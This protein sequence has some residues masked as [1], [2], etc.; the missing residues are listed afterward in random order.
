MVYFHSAAK[1]NC[2][3]VSIKHLPVA[4][5]PNFLPNTSVAAILSLIPA[6]LETKCRVPGAYGS[7]D[8]KI[9]GSIKILLFEDVT[10]MTAPASFLINIIF[11]FPVKVVAARILSC[12]SSILYKQ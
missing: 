11:T 3:M 8:V 4:Q 5:T 10:A 1:V 9:I 12:Y 6:R 2:K 7:P